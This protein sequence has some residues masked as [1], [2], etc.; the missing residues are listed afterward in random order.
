[1]VPIDEVANKMAMQVKQRKA[2]APTSHRLSVLCPY[3]F[4]CDFSDVRMEFDMGLLIGHGSK[5]RGSIVLDER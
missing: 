2:A 3:R 4:G 5:L 1:M